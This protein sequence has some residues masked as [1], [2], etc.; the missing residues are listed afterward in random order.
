M[1]SERKDVMMK[2]ANCDKDIEFQMLLKKI[3]QKVA[4]ALNIPIIYLEFTEISEIFDYYTQ[5]RDIDII[6]IDMNLKKENGYLIAKKLRNLDS[7]IKIIFLTTLK[8]YKV[9]AYDIYSTEY[10]IKPMEEEMLYKSVLSATKMLKDYENRYYIEKNK[11]GIYKIYFSD[12]KYIETSERHT[13]IHTLYGDIYSNRTL[14]SHINNLDSN[15][16]RCHNAII[17][18]MQYIKS[19]SHDEIEL[20]T[21]ETLPVSKNKK[22]KILAIIEFYL[23]GD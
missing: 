9:K 14:A 17:L 16:V 6:F 8:N 12:I 11:N 19:Y 5:L 23:K 20:K 15:F 10:W 13:V 21:G 3:V 1:I 7:K 2:V 22:K 4:L 18:N